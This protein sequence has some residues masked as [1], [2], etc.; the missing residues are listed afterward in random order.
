MNCECKGKEKQKCG[1]FKG[2]EDKETKLKHLKECK[3]GLLGKI[4]DIDAA[5]K[6]I[7]G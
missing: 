3:E 2:N 6:K 7:E 1:E 4:D 5:I